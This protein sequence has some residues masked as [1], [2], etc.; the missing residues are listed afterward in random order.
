MMSQL[1]TASRSF[2]SCVAQIEI[3]LRLCIDRGSIL[4]VQRLRFCWD[5][6]PQ[7]AHGTANLLIWF[8]IKQFWTVAR[9]MSS[10]QVLLFVQ[11]I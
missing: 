5:D 11:Y 10:I 6:Q 9:R 3:H 7:T 1:T 2:I 8:Q 4:L